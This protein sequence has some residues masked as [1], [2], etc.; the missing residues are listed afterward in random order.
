MFD[1]SENNKE[2]VISYLKTNFEDKRNTK[3]ASKIFKN[4]LDSPIKKNNSLTCLKQDTQLHTAYP[5]KKI[6]L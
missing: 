2:A 4:D 5:I 3:S 1:I 6:H